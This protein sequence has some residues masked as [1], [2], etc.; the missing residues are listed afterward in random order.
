MFLI[1]PDTDPVT[2]I[3]SDN[4]LKSLKAISTCFILTDVDTNYSL[5]GQRFQKSNENNLSIITTGTFSVVK[6]NGI[7]CIKS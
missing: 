5:T 2:L 3:F 1:W 6:L 7:V 4:V